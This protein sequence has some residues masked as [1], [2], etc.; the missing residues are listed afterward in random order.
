M[1]EDDTLVVDASL[2]AVRSGATDPTALIALQKI[3]VRLFTRDSLHAK[4]LVYD[5]FA[6]IGSANASR[7]SAK[8]LHEA[9]MIVRD[10]K[11]LTDLRKWARTL[12]I[13]ELTPKILQMLKKEYR[14]PRMNGGGQTPGLSSRL[15]ITWSTEEDLDPAF[16]EKVDARTDALMKQRS[17]REYLVE[18]IECPSKDKF[19]AGV[20]KNDRVIQFYH[21]GSRVTVWG[22]STVVDVK[23]WSN[24]TNLKTYVWLEY[25]DEGPVITADR[26]IKKAIDLGVKGLTNQSNKHIRNAETANALRALFVT[27]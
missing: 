16:A 21:E 7:N 2:K 19:T 8:S 5:K 11:I 13:D 9:C 12:Q 10:N 1:R 4:V 23:R 27:P 18:A 25:L 22:V 26:F 20:T 3:G 15:W 6:V 24:G 14:P 17:K